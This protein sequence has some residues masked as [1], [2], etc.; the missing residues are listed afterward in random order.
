MICQLNVIIKECQI[1]SLSSFIPYL[2]DDNVLIEKKKIYQLLQT[3]IVKSCLSYKQYSHNS[4]IAFTKQQCI[5]YQDDS[6]SMLDVI[7]HLPNYKASKPSQISNEMLKHLSPSTQHKL[8]ILVKAS[9][10]LHDIP[11]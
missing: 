7:H 8:W 5:N 3:L 11:T 6:K 9:L 4:I 10:T 1:L 2:N